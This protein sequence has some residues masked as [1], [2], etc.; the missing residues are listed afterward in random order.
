[1]SRGV[2]MSVGWAHSL[3]DENLSHDTKDFPFS[4]FNQMRLLAKSG[5]SQAKI[6]KLEA[7]LKQTGSAEELE[8]FIQAA[9]DNLGNMRLDPGAIETLI[10]GGAARSKKNG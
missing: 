2:G 1:M 6:E 9:I 5:V 8:N 10:R 3:S 7:L 4:L